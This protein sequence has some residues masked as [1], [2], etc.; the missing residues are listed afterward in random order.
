MEGL[1]TRVNEN[2][3]MEVQ[4]NL[5]SD[6]SYLRKFRYKA[7]WKSLDGFP[8]NSHQTRFVNFSVVEGAPYSIKLVAPTKEAADFQVTIEEQY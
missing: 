2:G 4:A 7:Q 3:F 8:I 5:Q 1:V 6:S